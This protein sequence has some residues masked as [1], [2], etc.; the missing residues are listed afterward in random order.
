MRAPLPRVGCERDTDRSR[1]PEPR[2]S[3]RVIRLRGAASRMTRREHWRDVADKIADAYGIVLLLV[4]T[5]VMLTSL[6]P[7]G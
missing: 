1:M 3:D 7:G 5:T 2:Q 6:L 4:M